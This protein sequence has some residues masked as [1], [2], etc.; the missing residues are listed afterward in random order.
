MFCLDICK[1]FSP[2]KIVTM[3]AAMAITLVLNQHLLSPGSKKKTCTII[4]TVIDASLDKMHH[5]GDLL[6]VM[7]VI[8]C[9]VNLSTLVLM[10]KEYPGRS[11]DGV[12][13]PRVSHCSP[14]LRYY[15]VPHNLLLYTRQLGPVEH[16][17]CREFCSSVSKSR[18]KSDGI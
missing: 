17:L 11:R 4:I 12:S 6:P 3:T 1:I 16:G 7:I 18:V 13:I 9:F 5:T 8:K 2:F 15:A 10:R 14:H